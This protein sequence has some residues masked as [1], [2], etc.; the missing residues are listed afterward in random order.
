MAK[1]ISDAEEADTS[2]LPSAYRVA[3]PLVNQ[4]RH[5]HR[6]CLGRPCRSAPDIC[7][8]IRHRIAA[9]RHFQASKHPPNW[10]RDLGGDVWGMAWG[11][12]GV[13]QHTGRLV[14]DGA[15]IPASIAKDINVQLYTGSHPGCPSQNLS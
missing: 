12:P 15:C 9:G 3:P 6:P 10:H 13:L 11:V 14:W 8:H 4:L 7:P 5:D 2:L 1:A